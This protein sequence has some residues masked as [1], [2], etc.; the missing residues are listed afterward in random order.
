MSSNSHPR[1]HNEYLYAKVGK[2]LTTPPGLSLSFASIIFGSYYYQQRQVNP[3]SL[4]PSDTIEESEPCDIS[5]WVP[6]P[7]YDTF[8]S[9]LLKPLHTLIINTS[10]NAIKKIDVTRKPKQTLSLNFNCSV[11]DCGCNVGGMSHLLSTMN[12]ISHV[13]GIDLSTNYIKYANKKY[14]NHITNIKGN[15]SKIKF[16]H[17]DAQNMKQFKENK[18]DIGYL[19]LVMHDM[20]DRVP[21]NILVEC[22]RVCRYVVVADWVGKKFPFNSVAGIRNG[23]IEFCV[24]PKHFAGFK[25]FIKIGGIEAHIDSIKKYIHGI[26]DSSIIFNKKIDNGTMNLFVINSSQAKTTRPHTIAKL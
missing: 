17:Q 14:S 18:F 5:S 9:S 21:M 2:F 26:D 25:H 11:L 22:C 20:P 7:L 1:P 8:Q 24:G 23:L 13:T 3:S 15:K 16:I 6:L 19:I 12:D 10:L 4:V